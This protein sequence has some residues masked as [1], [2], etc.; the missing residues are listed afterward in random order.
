VTVPFCGGFASPGPAQSAMQKH[1]EANFCHPLA[2]H[3]GLGV[4]MPRLI[5]QR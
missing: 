2:I 3:I 5:V 4:Q 1:I